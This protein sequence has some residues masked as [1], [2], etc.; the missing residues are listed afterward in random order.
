MQLKCLHSIYKTIIKKKGLN[1]F[2]P[3]RKKLNISNTRELTGWSLFG[4]VDAHG[5]LYKSFT[6]LP[7]TWPDESWIMFPDMCRERFL[8]SGLRTVTSMA[9]YIHVWGKSPRLSLPYCFPVATLAL[10]CLA[11][12]LLC[13]V[14]YRCFPPALTLLSRCI[15]PS[16]SLHYSCLL[17]T[18]RCV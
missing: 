12:V 14:L 18:S 17:Y 9:T 11:L 10:L 15:P 16:L 2:G 4:F 7:G 13:L 1:V 6:T 3:G 5:K 8:N